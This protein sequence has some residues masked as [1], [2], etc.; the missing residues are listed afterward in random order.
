MIVAI[1]IAVVALATW[2]YLLLGHGM[3]WLARER[4]DHGAP[5]SEPA[6][7]PSVVAVV[8][9]RNEADVIAVAL[10]SLLTQDYRGAINAFGNMAQRL[11]GL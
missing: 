7:W 4:D 10:S 1:A 9:A 5:E 8:P 2:L 11:H 3:F 6:R